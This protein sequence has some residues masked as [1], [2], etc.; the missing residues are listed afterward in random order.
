[1][2]DVAPQ[3]Q[4]W[5]TQRELAGILRVSEKTASVWAKAGRLRVFEHGFEMCG[6]RR[7]SRT[8]VETAIHQC[9][10]AACAQVS[11]A[12]KVPET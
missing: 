10:S 2:T 5:I 11:A 12:A 9:W 8:L 7:Y 4:D 1:M 3:P 6:R